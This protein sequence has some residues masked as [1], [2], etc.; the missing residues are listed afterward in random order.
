MNLESCDCRYTKATENNFP[1]KPHKICGKKHKIRDEL[2]QIKLTR[3]LMRLELSQKMFILY[4]SIVFL[5]ALL[6]GL[7]EF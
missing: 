6:I 4:G 2:P 5:D 7:N 3:H 1:P